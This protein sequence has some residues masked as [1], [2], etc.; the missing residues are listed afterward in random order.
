MQQ[1]ISPSVT[2][3]QESPED[4]LADALGGG[5]LLQLDSVET[6]PQEAHGADVPGPPPSQALGKMSPPAVT[7]LIVASSQEDDDL[8]ASSQEEQEE[9]EHNADAGSVSDDSDCAM[10]D[11]L[12]HCTKACHSQNKLIQ[13]IC[14]QL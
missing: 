6:S 7:D 1:L 11:Y 9:E 4:G 5:M 13:L 8:V 2:L 14:R 12:L 3:P 10:D